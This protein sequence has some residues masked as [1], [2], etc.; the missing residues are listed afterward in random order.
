MACSDAE[1]R[2]NAIASRGQVRENLCIV[3]EKCGKTQRDTRGLALNTRPIVS[4][5][6]S[7]QELEQRSFDFRVSWAIML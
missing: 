2:K 1:N 5:G 4:S 3:G 6:G 7:E